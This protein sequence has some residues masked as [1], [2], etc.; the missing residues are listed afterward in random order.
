MLPEL[1]GFDVYC[2]LRKEMTVPILI[3]TARTEE[4]DKIVCN[5][6]GADQ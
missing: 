1:N 2:I 6:I 3:L 4:I 5:E